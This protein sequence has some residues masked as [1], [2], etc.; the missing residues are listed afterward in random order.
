MMQFPVD[1]S[2]QEIVPFAVFCIFA[3]SLLVQLLYYWALY[4]RLAFYRDKGNPGPNKPVSVVICARNEFQN[5]QENLP[6]ILQQDYP[7]FEVVVVND[8]SDDDSIEL[9]ETLS[10]EY[11]NLKIFNLEKNLNFFQGKKFPLALGIKSARYDLILLTDADCKPSSTQWIRRMQA[12][13]DENTEIVIGY[14]A[15]EKQSSLL[16]YLIRFDAFN[17]AIQ[18]LSF[19]LAKMTYMGVGRNLS[20]TRKLFYRNKGFTGHYKLLSGDDDLFISRAANKLNTKVEIDHGS[21]TISRAK[22]SFGLWFFQKKRHY[23]TARLYRP[24]IK[25]LLSMNYVSKLAL[26]ISFILLLIIKYNYIYALGAFG[27]FVLTHFI[28]IK[29][30]ADKLNER[31]LTL[32]SIFLELILMIIS[33]LI[34]L[35]NLINKTDRWG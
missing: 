35:S 28:V 34:Y 8:S 3:I 17:V 29:F 5:L 30:C 33:P 6:L 12:R 15:Y 9:L 1:L 23:T 14:G 27:V 25:F 18:Y 4:S 13:Y 11:E 22:T 7:E 10:K 19:S 26:Y 31:D 16:N 2:I 24:W 32:P 21:H 20:Y